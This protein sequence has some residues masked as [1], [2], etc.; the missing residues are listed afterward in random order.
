[1]KPKLCLMIMTAFL[2][3]GATVFASPDVSNIDGVL[4]ISGNI[5]ITVP[6]TGQVTLRVLKKGITKEEFIASPDITKCFYFG[7]QT[8]S[9]DGSYNFQVPMNDNDEYGEYVIIADNQSVTYIHAS[10]EDIKLRTAVMGIQNAPNYGTVRDI[11]KANKQILGITADYSDEKLLKIAN[12]LYPKRK[13]I[14]VSNYRTVIAQAESDAQE[15]DSG[16]GG[17]GSGGGSSSKGGGY[18]STAVGYNP[19]TTEESTAVKPRFNDVSKSHW[20]Y[21]YI[22]DLAERGIISGR[23]DGN[24]APSNEI[25]R[26]EFAKILAQSFLSAS[27]ATSDGTFTDVKNG[28]WYEGY[29]YA[30]YKSGIVNG[31]ADGQFGTGYLVTKQD[32]AVMVHRALTLGGAELKE[33]STSLSDLEDVSDYAKEAVKKLCSQG[34]INGNEDGMFQPQKSLTRAEAAKII[35]DSLKI[36]KGKV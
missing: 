19:P 28:A 14:T 7:E 22:T 17:G 3:T 13:T 11:L 20:A 9:E 23:D 32:A 8:V 16:N 2:A 33:E 5:D 30:M 15:K 21:G 24:F 12:E 6:N 35:S 29:V 34:I 36:M 26:E 31:I 18:V 10:Q 1:M 25:R 27:E 4:N